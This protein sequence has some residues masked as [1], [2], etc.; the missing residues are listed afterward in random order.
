MESWVVPLMIVLAFAVVLLSPMLGAV[1]RIRRRVGLVC[2]MTK[3]RV[4]VEFVEQ[5]ALG[6]SKA[7][8][9]CACSEFSDPT[10][11]TCEKKC[12]S[13]ADSPS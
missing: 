6:I 7:E 4:T 10:K 1:D 8:D 11:V 5:E 2:P 3:R 9:V 13:L 12:L